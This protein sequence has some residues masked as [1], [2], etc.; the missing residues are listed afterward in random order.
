MDRVYAWTAEHPLAVAVLQY[1]TFFIVCL[2]LAVTLATMAWLQVV[3]DMRIK[4]RNDVLQRVN[5][6]ERTSGPRTI[7]GFLHPFANAFG[8]GERVLYEA[9]A[10]HQRLDPAVFCVVYTGQLDPLPDGATKDEIIA[11]AKER[12]GIT[13]DPAKLEFLPLKY[14][15]MTGDKYWSRFTLLGQTLGTIWMAQDAMSRLIPDVFIDTTGHAFVLPIVKRVAKDVRVGS[16]VHYPTVSTDMLAR[17]QQRRAG[18]TN[19]DAVAKSALLSTAKLYYYRLFALAYGWALRHADVLAVNGSWTRAHIEQIMRH[20]PFRSDRKDSE[21]PPIHVVYPPCDT[22]SFAVFPLQGRKQS[23]IVSLAQFRPEKEHS[24]QLKIIKAL[25]DAHPELRSGE[26]A[27]RLVMI[28]SVRGREDAV[29][30]ARLRGQAEELGIDKHV[31]FE[32]D[33][34]FERLVQ[35]VGRSSIGLST[36]VDEH[37]GINVVEFMA[38]GLIT[39]SHASAGPLLDIAV[40]VDGKPTGFHAKDV[41]EYAETLYKLITLNTGESLD[42]RQRARQRAIETFGVPSFVQSWRSGLWD[43]LRGHDSKKD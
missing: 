15:N 7:V 21:I 27:P 25:L 34:T 18:H 29:R 11:K 41:N 30:V 26:N 12:F 33:A 28:G 42:I 40:P 22:T 24:T 20:R 10:S 19:S 16:Y 35:L 6:S 9:I 39:L 14:C 38:A 32:V 1:G 37:F 8:G 3:R 31:V 36:M 43:V 5:V 13:L 2:V 23:D 4:N 17:V